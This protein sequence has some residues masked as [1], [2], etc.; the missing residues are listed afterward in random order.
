MVD[1]RILEAL[2]GIYFIF[3][4]LNDVFQT[5]VVPSL[6]YTRFRLLPLV[7]GRVMWPIW[8]QI[9]HK[10][11][12]P[13]AHKDFLAIF[14]PLSV[15]SILIVWI[16]FLLIGYALVLFSIR[17]GTAPPLVDLQSA[18]YFAGTSVFTI[19]FGDITPTSKVARVV[20]LI[21]AVSGLTTM[22]LVTSLVFSIHNAYQRREN[23]VLMLE[24]RAGDPPSGLTLLKNIG[25]NQM[26]NEMQAFFSVWEMWCAEV[27]TS[28]SSY[29]FLLFF[30]S[31]PINSSWLTALGCIL[32]ATVLSQSIAKLNM[33]GQARLTYSMGLRL[34]AEFSTYFNLKDHEYVSEHD[35]ELFM[36][37]RAV[38]QNS[39]YELRPEPE[40]WQ[41]FTELRAGYYSLIHSFSH[42][43]AMPCCALASSDKEPKSVGMA[44]SA[45]AD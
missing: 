10:I 29:T 43:L 31:K 17:D 23:F 33:Q 25:L 26:Q 28:H 1:I 4:V 8:R 3:I 37:A 18:F 19:G 9:S 32:D 34:L 14:A 45:L 35:R 6:G 16:T 39:G 38:L 2:L 30:R 24:G 41:K 21:A 27:I 7:V 40:S 5:V 36:H 42:H 13:K 44:Q 22:A 15:V 12:D 11:T 20:I